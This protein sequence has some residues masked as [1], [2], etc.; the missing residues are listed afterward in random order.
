MKQLRGMF[1]N[2]K[3]RLNRLRYFLYGLPLSIII[4]I[5]YYITMYNLYFSMRTSTY[6]LIIIYFLVL[7][8]CFISGI[9]LTIR[10]L[11]DLNLS[12]WFV[13]IELLS[14]I[15]FVKIIPAIFGLY[16]LFAPGKNDGNYYGDDP[17]NYDHYP[18]E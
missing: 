12:G 13:L 3:G 14:L 8:I 11:H 18:Y 16:L 2:F 5:A 15:P 10:R 7:I 17:L 6:I 1:F 4:G 9:S